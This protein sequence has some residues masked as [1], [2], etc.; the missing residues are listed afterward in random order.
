ML[1]GPFLSRDFALR[2]AA[3]PA[4]CRLPKGFGARLR[5]RRVLAC[6]GSSRV[7]YG[8]SVYGTVWDRKTLRCKHARKRTKVCGA[9]LPLF[10]LQAVVTLSPRGPSARCVVT[11]NCAGEFGGGGARG[12][13]LAV[14][15]SPTAVGPAQSGV[16]NCCM[17]AVTSAARAADAELGVA[18]AQMATGSGSYYE[19]R[20]TKPAH[21]PSRFI[22]ALTIFHRQ[23]TQ[24]FWP[25]FARPECSE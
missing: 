5:P 2:V 17:H 25:Q 13:R 4:A 21:T 12:G 3:S 22:T 8:H 10:P 1:A 15:A 20:S 14:A 7:P 9:D 23:A 6:A 11:C 19:R 18:A 24:L 16:S